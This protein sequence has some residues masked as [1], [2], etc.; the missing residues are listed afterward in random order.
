M[1]NSP[2]CLLSRPIYV[3][4]LIWPQPRFRKLPTSPLIGARHHFKRKRPRKEH[5]TTQ[6]RAQVADKV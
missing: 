5:E 4:K 6:M 3:D 1:I 2:F